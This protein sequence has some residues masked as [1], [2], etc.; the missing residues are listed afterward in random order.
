MDKGTFSAQLA[1]VRIGVLLGTLDRQRFQVFGQLSNH[2]QTI[3][4]VFQRRPKH[5]FEPLIQS[6]F[7]FGA[8][9]FRPPSCKFHRLFLGRSGH[10]QK[11]AHFRQGCVMI[12][13]KE[14]F[15]GCLCR[16]QI[17]QKTRSD[18]FQTT[19]MVFD[20]VPRCIFGQEEQ[21]K[22]GIRRF[23]VHARRTP[24]ED[25]RHL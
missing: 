5:N 6:F 13:L 11:A 19:Q 2:G 8:F 24:F 22:K 20:N 9:F 7:C 17:D 25:L 23:Q 15:H 18:N 12:G 1:N 10:F 14:R 16:F 4:R 3:Q 21:A